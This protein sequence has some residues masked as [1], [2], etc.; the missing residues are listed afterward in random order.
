MYAPVTST[1]ITDADAVIFDW[2]GVLVDS[3]RYYYRAYELVLQEVGITTTPREIYLR[4]GQP[5][6]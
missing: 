5:T 6:P 1:Q 2:D 4:E 3:S